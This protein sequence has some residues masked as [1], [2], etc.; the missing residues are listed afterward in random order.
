MVAGCTGRRWVGRFPG[1]VCPAAPTDMPWKG[2]KLFQSEIEVPAFL[3]EYCVYEYSG[4]GAPDPAATA[5]LQAAVAGSS[6]CTFTEDCVTVGPLTDEKEVD[7]TRSILHDEFIQQVNGAALPPVN[8]G[9]TLAIARVAVIDTKAGA[10]TPENPHATV[11]GGLIRDLTCSDPG[12]R[13]AADVTYELGLPHLNNIKLDPSGGHFGS[14]SQVATAI[15]RSVSDWQSQNY[16]APGVPPVNPR[17][18][19]NASIGA[20]PG[21]DCGPN[22]EQLSCAAQSA[23]DAIRHATCQGALVVAAAGNSPGGELRREPAIDGSGPYDFSDEEVGLAGGTCPAAWTRMISRD[24]CEGIEGAKYDALFINEGYAPFSQSSPGV[25]AQTPLLV[26]VAG[27]DASNALLPNARKGSLPRNVAFGLLGTATEDPMLPF[28]PP[29]TGSSLGA[30][31]WTATAVNTWAYQPELTARELIDLLHATGSPIYDAQNAVRTAKV[32]WDHAVP[33]EKVKRPSAC[34]AIAKICSSTSPP[35]ACPAMPM[36]ACAPFASSPTQNHLSTLQARFSA[37]FA[38]TTA[39][40][41][42]FG[43][44]PKPSTDVPGDTLR[45]L[46]TPSWIHPQPETFPCGNCAFNLG[47]G[48]VDI[49]INPSFT[50][51]IRTA[52]LLL[53]DANGGRLGSALLHFPSGMSHPAKLSYTIN[54]LPA[55]TAQAE[56]SFEVESNGVT[57]SSTGTILLMK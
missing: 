50:S 21:L 2:R 28:P 5:A 14:M 44:T 53:N 34:A 26:P 48:N 8:P 27:V 39:T 33:P 12:V 42:D 24:E 7:A 30:A 38:N 45:N 57:G 22:A 32:D 31:A 49:Y 4:A 16:T 1:G 10:Q 41:A 20:Q 17:L 47:L 56:I 43:S 52:R 51:T 29:M 19:I 35:A 6:D 18:V 23:Y 15:Y 46:S 40:K 9:E 11:V 55:N 37:L 25:W 36:P 54:N 3:A 13:C